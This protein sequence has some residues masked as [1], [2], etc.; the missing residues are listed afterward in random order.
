MAN[1]SKSRKFSE[2]DPW[3]TVFRVADRWPRGIPE[4]ALAAYGRAREEGRIRAVLVTV[5]RATGYAVVEYESGIPPEFIREELKNLTNQKEEHYEQ[6]E[7][8]L[9]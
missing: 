6:H 3:G 9:G 2:A 8:E 7:I 4:Y 5:Q 1:E